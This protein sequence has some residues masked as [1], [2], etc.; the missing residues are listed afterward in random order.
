MLIEYGLNL[1]GKG[2]GVG[3]PE[4]LRAHY[5]NAECVPKNPVALRVVA[6]LVPLPTCPKCD[7]FAQ[8]VLRDLALV[9]PIHEAPGGHRVEV[10][11]DARRAVDLGDLAA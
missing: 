4:G 1:E 8:G 7:L 11:R 2:F 6:A 9:V 3:P 5:V 10:L